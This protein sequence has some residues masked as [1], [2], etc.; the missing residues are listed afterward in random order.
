[1]WRKQP[2]DANLNTLFFD[3]LEER[4][5]VR[6]V[7][8]EVSTGGLCRTGSSES[9][10]SIQGVSDSDRSRGLIPGGFR[11]GEWVP[12]TLERDEAGYPTHRTFSER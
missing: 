7:V 2:S 5:H 9:D 1:M 6:R 4:K 8:P 3:S 10:R 11:G 12:R